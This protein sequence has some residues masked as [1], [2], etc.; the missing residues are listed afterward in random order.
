MDLKWWGRKEDWRVFV[1]DSAHRLKPGGGARELIR[2]IPAH[3][4]IPE[5]KVPE[6]Y[7]AVLFEIPVGK[8]RVWVCDLDLENAISIDPAAQ[9]FTT[10][11]LRAAADPDS[12][13][14]LPVVP[15]HQEQLAGVAIK[16]K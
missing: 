5:E 11:L 4:Y 16:Q 13:R 12:T 9:L 2:F 10:N 3:S 1:A 15:S 8:G 14:K 7:M 6:Q